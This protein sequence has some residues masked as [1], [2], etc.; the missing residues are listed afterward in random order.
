MR[1]SVVIP[2]HNGRH[3]LEKHLLAVL[4][5][6]R[7]G[8]EVIVVDDASTDN[9]VEFLKETYPLVHLVQHKNTLRYAQSCNDGVAVAKNP[10]IF[11]LNNDVSPDP[12]ALSTVVSHFAHTM[13]GAVGFLEYDAS[14]KVQGRSV[15][16]FQRGMFVHARAKEQTAGPTMWAAGGS[17]VMRTDLWKKLGG[18]DTLFRPAY[19]EDIDLGYRTWKA[20]FGV[21]FEPNSLVFHDHE[22]TNLSVFGKTK[23]EIMS[24]K[25]AFL[26]LWK[27]VTDTRILLSHLLWLPYHI[28]YGGLRSHGLLIFGLIQAVLQ[29]DEVLRAR[30]KAGKTAVISDQNVMK[31]AHIGGSI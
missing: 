28:I 11:L 23:I 31:N 9:S 19:S 24:Y 26:F 18:M 17:M 12:N 20:G 3:L 30:R 2:T 5:C 14:G 16:S 25:N 6:L 21:F 29:M 10:L 1:V 4:A 13:V 22:T 15:G 27:N 7:S 8:D